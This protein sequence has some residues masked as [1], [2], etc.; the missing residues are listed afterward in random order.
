MTKTAPRARCRLHSL[1]IPKDKCIFSSPRLTTCVANKVDEE[2]LPRYY[3]H[4]KVMEQRA[5][6][7]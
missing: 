7:R 2:E 1:Y 5:P 3:Y 4:K 6:P